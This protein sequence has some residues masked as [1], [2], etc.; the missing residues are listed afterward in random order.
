MERNNT[1]IAKL[2]NQPLQVIS[3]LFSGERIITMEQ[4][5]LLAKKCYH[6]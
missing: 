4:Y 2:M 1:G 5:G 6:R 3:K